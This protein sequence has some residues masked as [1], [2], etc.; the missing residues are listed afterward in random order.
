M[1]ESVAAHTIKPL[2]SAERIAASVDELAR[3]IAVAARSTTSSS[4]PC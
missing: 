2:F 3:D 1:A 4:S